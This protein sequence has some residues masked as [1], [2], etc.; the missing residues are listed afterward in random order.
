MAEAVDSYCRFCH[1]GPWNQGC[2]LG[3]KLLAL[4]LLSFVVLSCD[5]FFLCI[6]C[7]LWLF[8]S[9]TGMEAGE[10]LACFR[11]FPTS[12]VL[13]VGSSPPPDFAPSR[14]SSRFLNVPAIYV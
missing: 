1:L 13:V 10:S 8:G 4:L 14:S 6:I 9:T 3:Q 5:C 7:L 2:D 12:L 11:C